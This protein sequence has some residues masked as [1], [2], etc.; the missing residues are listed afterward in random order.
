MP[1]KRISHTETEVA[2]VKLPN[3]PG[4]LR[5]VASELGGANIN[6]EYAYS[7]LD[8]S[9]SPVAFFCVKDVNKAVAV[10]DKIAA[11]A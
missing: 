5:R 7:G 11:A 8:A 1:R 9:N 10:L 4:E 6:I 3:R 2:Q